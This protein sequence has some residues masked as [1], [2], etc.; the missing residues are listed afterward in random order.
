MK[1][2]FFSFDPS[3]LILPF[4][5]RQNQIREVFIFLLAVFIHEAGHLLCLYALGYKSP[6]LSFS[7]MGAKILLPSPYIP[8]RKEIFIYLAGPFFNLL[9]CLGGVFL[10]R[11]RFC[12]DFIFFFFSNFLLAFFNLLPLTGLDGEGALFAFLSLKTTPRRRDK[13]L[14]KTRTLFFSLFFTFALYIFTTG[15]NPSLI[16]LYVL[17][18]ME[19]K[20]R[21]ATK[22]S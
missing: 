21:K 20:R 2:S 6:R 17:L 9:S 12:T 10:L 4:F 19:Q 11:Y 7:L 14:A 3:L 16:L 22:N 1:K 15:K 13:I 5:F 18:K 8:Y